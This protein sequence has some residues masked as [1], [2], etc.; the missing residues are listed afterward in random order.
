MNERG[1]EQPRKRVRHERDDYVAI[2]HARMPLTRGKSKK[3]DEQSVAY[4]ILTA[5]R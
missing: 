1:G 2:L 5:A 4:D 3:A